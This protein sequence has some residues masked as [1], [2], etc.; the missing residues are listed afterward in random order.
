VID[1]PLDEAET[2]LT[3]GRAGEAALL[4]GRLIGEGRGGLLARRVW[5]KALAASGDH[6]GALEAARETAS[7]F[8]GIAEAALGLG[9][10]LLAGEQLPTAIAE[11]QRALRLDPELTEARFLLGCAWLA[12]GEAGRALEAFAAVTP[13][14][15]GL[16]EH[17]ARAEAMQARPRSD[18]GYVRHLFDQFSTDYDARM[19]SQLCY[20]APQTLRELAGLVMPGLVGLEV[21]DLGCGTGLSGA[22]FKDRALRLDGIDLSPAMLEKARARGIYDNLT[23]GDIEA[24]FGDAAYDLVVAADTLVYL[25]ELAA[26]MTAVAAALRGGGFF[27]FTVEAKEGEGFELGPKRRWRHSENYLRALAAKH[28]FE[29][30]GLMACVPRQEAHAAVNG[31]AVALC[32]M[33][34]QKSG[35]K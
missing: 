13:Q 21:L 30:A 18:A 16:A 7:L 2:L 26:T 22:A 35:R 23:V 12:A 31:Y 17:V 27:L 14:T 6:A 33:P 4:L 3:A 28:G 24:G 34:V 11:F 15:P 5:A 29:I 10:V 8:P 20:R 9:E 1:N 25:G 19:L 32:K